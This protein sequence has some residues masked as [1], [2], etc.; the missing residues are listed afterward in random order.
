[1]A[2]PS[3]TPIILVVV[4]SPTCLSFCAFSSFTPGDTFLRALHGGC[5]FIGIQLNAH[6]ITQSDTK[7][8]W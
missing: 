1:M 3:D 8:V 7:V 4:F 5:G 2:L 6:G